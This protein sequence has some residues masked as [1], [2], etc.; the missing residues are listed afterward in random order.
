MSYRLGE[1]KQLIMFPQSIEE[2][3][4][5]DHPVRVY[6]T[7]VETLDFAELGIT[8]DKNQV[9]N[10]AYDPKAML[11]LLLY[12]YSYGIRSSRKLERAIH[13]NVSFMWLMGGLEPDHKTIARFRKKN[14]KALK[15]VLKQ[16]ARFC[17]KMGLIAGNT[18]FVDGTKIRANAGIKNTWTPERCEKYLK[19]IDERIE[20]I[21]EECAQNDEAEEGEPS[22]VK[23]PEELLEKEKLKARVQEIMAELKE[24][25][26]ESIN[27]TDADCVKVKSGEGIKAGYNGQIVVDEKNGLIVS[28]D[29]VSESNDSQQFAKQIEQANEVLEKKCEKACADAGYTNT[30]ELKKVDEQEIEVI[31]PTTKQAHNSPSLPFSKEKFDY[32]TEADCYICPEGHKL[33]YHSFCK[34]KK[35]R[36][37][38]ITDKH[39]CRTCQHFGECTKSASGRRIRRLEEEEI[40]EKLE[41]KYEQESGQAVYKLR[42][43]KVELPFGHIKRNLGATS[44]L[45]RGIE[46][47]KAEMAL[48]ASCF[49]L[50]RMI[51][52][53]G[54]AE[55]RARLSCS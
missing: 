29:V 39:L 17:L 9:G 37:Y 46:G 55:L 40:K 7:F 51:N 22:L 24:Q 19:R 23:V 47:V 6:D 12:G 33:K 4:S 49:N 42:K 34:Q 8:I 25:G 10:P 1:R 20:A 11:K 48:F 53:V 14:Q 28:S 31:V 43:Q 38:R 5:K 30:E 35:H 36:V 50:V 41:Q 45:L 3:V 2:Y 15:N 13:D 44:F 32:D 54:V 21:L 18:L 16:C 26:K 27:T 52:L